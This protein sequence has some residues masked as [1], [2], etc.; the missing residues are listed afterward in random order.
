MQLRR[1]LGC[2][3]RDETIAPSPLLIA[4]HRIDHAVTPHGFGPRK[5][6][7]SLASV[8][9]NGSLGDTFQMRPQRDIADRISLLAPGTSLAQGATLRYIEDT[10]AI[11]PVK[12]TSSRPQ[13]CY[14]P[15]MS[16]HVKQLIIL[17]PDCEVHKCYRH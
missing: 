11:N 12:G 15:L 10:T 9:L 14:M 17:H 4:E 8:C 5:W 3:V 7:S 16:G 1:D 2:P 6:T 13:L